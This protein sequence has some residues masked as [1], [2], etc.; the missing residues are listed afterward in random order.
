[1][2]QIITESIAVLSIFLC[3]VKCPVCIFKELL[4]CI[5]GNI[6][7]KK[8]D[9]Y[10]A[11]CQIRGSG[12]F[13]FLHFPDQLSC[14]FHDSGM[15]DVLQKNH[16]FI[17]TQTHDHII[18]VEQSHKQL[19]KTF[20]DFIT[21]HMSVSIIYIFKIIYIKHHHPASCIG[22]SGCKIFID[23]FFSEKAVIQSGQRI[24]L[25]T[26]LKKFFL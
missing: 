18:D 24:F 9:P 2:S 19:C 13:E 25:G 12:K 14:L 26:F 16:K 10:T 4:I 20:Q 5:S 22:I 17:A 3:P 6:F 21:E 11:G 15:S 23:Q 8:A 1:M 7:R